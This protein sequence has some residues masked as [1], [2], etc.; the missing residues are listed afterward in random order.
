VTVQK[1][2]LVDFE[3]GPTGRALIDVAC[4]SGTYVRSLADDIGREAGCGACLGFLLRTA[5]GRFSLADA[6]TLEELSA[7]CS[8]G[9]VEELLLGVD[10]PLDHLGAIDLEASDAR[11]FAH[12]TCVRAGDSKAWPVR[13]YGPGGSFLGLGEVLGK[14][15]LCAR[16][17]VAPDRSG[18][19]C[20]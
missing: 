7:V 19:A 6:A 11:S 8:T 4:S 9:S 15:R 14:G 18:E 20:G 17:V 12:G 10:Y 2:E 3:P 5:A 13:V 16:L 1:L